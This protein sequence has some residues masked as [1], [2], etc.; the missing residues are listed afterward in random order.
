MNADQFAQSALS[1]QEHDQLVREG[2]E[3]IAKAITTVKL[4]YGREIAIE[5]INFIF[6]AGIS[7]KE[8]QA[9]IA[10]WKNGEKKQEE[11]SNA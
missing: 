8:G 1:R 3:L 7:T 9:I 2:S 6:Q 4:L 10:R 5:S 11:P